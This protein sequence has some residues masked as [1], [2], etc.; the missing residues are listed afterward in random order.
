MKQRKQKRLLTVESEVPA[1]E[2]QSDVMG[3]MEAIMKE[4]ELKH[5]DE[6][7]ALMQVI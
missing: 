3:W 6:R 4:V 7:E 1:P 2:N 5:A